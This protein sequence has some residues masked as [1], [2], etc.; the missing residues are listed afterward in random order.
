MHGDAVRPQEGVCSYDRCSSMQV[1]NTVQ[2]ALRP[3]SSMQDYP[4]LC[5]N[6]LVS[7]CVRL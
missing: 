5:E 3:S 4:R 6:V 2:T 1:S 7:I